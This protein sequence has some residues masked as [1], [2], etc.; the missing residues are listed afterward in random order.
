MA[1]RLTATLV[2]QFFHYR[3]ERQIRYGMVASKERRS[4]TILE[5]PPREVWAEF[6]ID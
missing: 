5:R 2:K 3:C 6:G 4:L 1:L